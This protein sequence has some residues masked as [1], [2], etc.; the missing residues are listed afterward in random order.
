VSKRGLQSAGLEQ[1]PMTSSS[2]EQGD[3]RLAPIGA[4]RMTTSC[5][6]T[7]LH[8]GVLGMTRLVLVE[9]HRFSN[10]NKFAFALD[11]VFHSE[12]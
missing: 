5:S 9:S 12:H 8:H 1:V 4:G 2:C 6:R 7:T 10:A 11:S 3:E